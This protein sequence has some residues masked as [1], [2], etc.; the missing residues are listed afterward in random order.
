MGVLD[1]KNSFKQ[2]MHYA[3]QKYDQIRQFITNATLT[4]CLTEGPK[5]GF[6]SNSIVQDVII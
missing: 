1:S 5:I 2:Q 4:I 3:K 6:D